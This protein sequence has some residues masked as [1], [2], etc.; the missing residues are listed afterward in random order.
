LAALEATLRAYL[1]PQTVDKTLPAY[2]LI[3]RPLAEIEAMTA[4]VLAAIECWAERR[5]KV[6]VMPGKSQV[7]S[8]SLP[9]ATLPTCMIALTPSGTSVESLAHEL[10]ALNPPVIGRMQGGKVLLDM[11]CL[12]DTG[13]LLRAL[14]TKGTA[15]A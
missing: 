11:R 1:T 6:A 10:R 12:L 9:G 8:G 5:A 4:K 3:S 2:R 15:S 14:R 7:G 13:L